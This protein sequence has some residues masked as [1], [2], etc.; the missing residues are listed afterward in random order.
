MVMHSVH[1]QNYRLHNELSCIIVSNGI[2]IY[3][4]ISN[5]YCRSFLALFVTAVHAQRVYPGACPEV[6]PMKDFELPKVRF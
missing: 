3:F 1:N 5:C 6:I 4:F 2:N